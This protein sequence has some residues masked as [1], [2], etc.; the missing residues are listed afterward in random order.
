MVYCKSEECPVRSTCKIHTFY[1][2]APPNEP[3]HMIDLYVTSNKQCTH[4]EYFDTTTKE[5]LLVK[6]NKYRIENLH[7]SEIPDGW[8]IAY[9]EG[10]QETA[11]NTLNTLLSIFGMNSRID[12]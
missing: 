5:T 9:Q 7:V 11:V 2:D 10:Q 3:I 8:K 4:Y 6:G 12:E 1:Q